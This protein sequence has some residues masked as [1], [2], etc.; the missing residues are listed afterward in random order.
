ME[1]PFFHLWMRPM[2]FSSFRKRVY[3]IKNMPPLTFDL[4]L[5]IPTATKVTPTK[6]VFETNSWIKKYSLFTPIVLAV[7]SV[8]CLALTIFSACFSKVE[9]EMEFD[10]LERRRYRLDMPMSS[11]EQSL[12]S[13]DPTPMF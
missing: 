8:L 5:P 13:F 11:Y 2:P 6:V 10:Y 12:K 4:K 7:V 1:S 9:Q 3:Q